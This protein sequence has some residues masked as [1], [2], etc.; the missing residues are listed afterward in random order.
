MG[1]N[2][3]LGAFVGPTIK[4][5]VGELINTFVLRE[6]N[7]FVEPVDVSQNCSV[8]VVIFPVLMFCE[9]REIVVMDEIVA[10]NI[11]LPPMVY[12][13]LSKPAINEYA[14]KGSLYVTA[15]AL[16]SNVC[17]AAAVL[18]VIELTPNEPRVS[19]KVKIR[20]GIV[21]VEGSIIT[22]GRVLV[23]NRTSSADVLIKEV[24][25]VYLFTHCKIW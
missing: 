25:I 11:R 6:N 24:A 15:L 3:A 16:F 13:L 1:V 19:L 10:A 17:V 22:P 20:P 4:K 5:F 23:F 21:F 14:P 9:F 18:N 7:V 8:L 12:H 2:R